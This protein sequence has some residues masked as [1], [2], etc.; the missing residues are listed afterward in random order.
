MACNAEKTNEET[1]TAASGLNAGLGDPWMHRSQ[2]MRCRTCMWWVEKLTT[3][4]PGERGPVGR[5]RRHCPTMNGF[6]V[7]FASD[8][9]GDHRLDES[10]G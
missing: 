3:V 4:E 2:G 6:P 7:V 1:V 9:C 5:C 8:W 10:K